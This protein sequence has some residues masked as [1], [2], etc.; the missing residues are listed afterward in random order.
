MP[1]LNIQKNRLKKLAAIKKAGINPYPTKSAKTHKIRDVL[2]YFTKLAGDKTKVVLCGRL[3][4]IREHGGLTFFNFDDGTGILQALLSRDKIGEKK[5]QFFSDSFDIGDFIEVSGVLF[6][7]KRGEKT[8]EVTDF[9]ILA[10]SLLP[11]P[12]KWHGLQDVEERFRK[13]YLDLIMNPEVRRKF[14][15]RSNILKELRKILW[16]NGFLEVETPILQPIPGGAL[17]KPFKTH[18]NALKLDLY[19]RVAPELYLKRLLVGGFEKI[20]EIGRCF[21]NEGMDAFHN[22]DFTM[23]ELY[24]AYQDRDGLME[25]VEETMLEL[26]K[27]LGRANNQIEYQDNQIDF[28]IPWKRSTFRE[29]VREYCQI[30]IEKASQESLKKKLNSLG[31]KVEKGAPKCQLVDELYKKVCQPKLIQPTFMIDHPIEMAVLAKAKEGEPKYADRFQLIVGG[32]EMINGFSEL[33]DPHEQRKR[34]EANNIARERRD[35]D[36]LEALEYGMPPAAGLGIGIDR[37][38]SLLTDSHSLREAILFPTMRPQNK[39]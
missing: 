18:L 10:K 19:L 13:R 32:I 8:V 1:I 5:Y 36:F 20:Y 30:D 28:K 14:I 4:S 15:I 3:R 31:V 6:T 27:N 7:T 11:L 34:F 2:T 26:L 23:L 22:P 16:A 12:E 9:R 17:A 21:R 29:I 35:K 38:V 25:F 37:L 39:K 24:W 33:N